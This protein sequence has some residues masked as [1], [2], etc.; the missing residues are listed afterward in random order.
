MKKDMP[1]AERIYFDPLYT[2]LVRIVGW[3]GFQYRE[4]EEKM[5]PLYERFDKGKV[6]AAVYH[7]ATYEGDNRTNVKPLEQVML[8]DHVRPL[9]RGL[10]GF[11]PE[12]QHLLHSPP[13]GSLPLGAKAK[14]EPTKQETLDTMSDELLRIRLLEA[15]KKLCTMSVRSKLGKKLKYEIADMIQ[16]CRRR[17]VPNPLMDVPE[18]Q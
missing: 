12:E 18:K 16:E 4:M 14:K 1:L 13:A 10:L 9:C 5:A 8:R 7:L 2:E 6:Q 17:G 15:D 11:L 3:K